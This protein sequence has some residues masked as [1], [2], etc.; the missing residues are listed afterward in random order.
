MDSRKINSTTKISL[1]PYLA[2]L[3]INPKE[4]NST[5]YLGSK[6]SSLGLVLL[7]SLLRMF[8]VTASIPVWMAVVA[9]VGSGVACLERVVGA[10]L[11]CVV[12]NICRQSLYPWLGSRYPP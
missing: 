8:G 1:I 10:I 12:V 6:T 3:V 5:D 4:Q 2:Y 11:V 7:V 9:E